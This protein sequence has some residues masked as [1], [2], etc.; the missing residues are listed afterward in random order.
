MLDLGPGAPPNNRPVCE[1]C[2]SYLVGN[3]LWCE[4]CPGYKVPYFD[5]VSCTCQHNTLISENVSFH[6]FIMLVGSGQPRAHA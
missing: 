1:P 4:P 3:G 2:P 5:A 6:P